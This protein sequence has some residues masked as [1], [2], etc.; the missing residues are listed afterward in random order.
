MLLAEAGR[1]GARRVG[2]AAAAGG[3]VLELVAVVFG[4]ADV[5]LLDGLLKDDALLVVGRLGPLLAERILLLRPA[6]AWLLR[7]LA[8]QCELVDT[9]ALSWLA[10]VLGS[11]LLVH[12]DGFFGVVDAR[13]VA[14]LEEILLPDFRL[15]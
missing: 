2:L 4:E 12:L 10:V 3:G 7:L 9:A 1:L 13:L 11:L 8:C 5:A 14:L 6:A 15:D